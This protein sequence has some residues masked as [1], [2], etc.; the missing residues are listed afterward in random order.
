MAQI[1]E[2]H[3]EEAALAWLAELG[4]AIANGL[5]IGPDGSAPERASYGDVIL[6]E[7]LKAAIARL[8]SHLN[9]D[10]QEEVFRR[11]TQSETPSLTEENRRLHRF[12]IEGVPVEITRPYGSIGGDTARLID[13]DDLA[14]ND[15]LAVNQFT[16]I[17]NKA[18]RRPDVVVFVNGLPLGV[19]ELKNPGAENAA[20]D[21]AFNQLQTYKAQIPS[22]FRT[23]AA[24]V[25]SDG[26]AARIGSL[27]ATQERFMP[28]R[29]VTGETIA[30]KG[31]P[32]LETLLKGV[33]D[34]GNFLT[35]MKVLSSLAIRAAGLSRYW[36]AI[37]SFMRCAGLW[38]RPCALWA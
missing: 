19:I 16:V 28:W 17:E 15:W 27:T 23:N 35:L 9:A 1:A 4:Y 29:T 26:L 32:E 21:G 24:L 13:F 3:V 36:R 10:T 11:L 8:N 22:L 6:A 2:S 38:F 12:L 14:A 7:R 37:T 18:N 20:L 31:T 25:I 34:Q 5:A 30:P 33:F